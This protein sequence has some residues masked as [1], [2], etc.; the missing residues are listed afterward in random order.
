MRQTGASS[1]FSSR[2]LGNLGLQRSASRMGGS[3]SGSVMVEIYQQRMFSWSQIVNPDDYWYPS[4]MTLRFAAHPNITA[5]LWLTGFWPGI[6]W[7]DGAITALGAVVA[8]IKSVTYDVEGDGNKTA[9]FAD[10]RA[11]IRV[12][13]IVS[14]RMFLNVRFATAK[15][16]GIITYWR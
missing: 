5:Q 3:C 9:T 1:A 13:R 10:V 4:Y 7:S 15:A 11:S 14:L 6:S 2:D 16:E 12:E 8:G